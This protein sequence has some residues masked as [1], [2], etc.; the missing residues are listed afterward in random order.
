MC[1]QS[2][3]NKQQLM[4]QVCT[5][6]GRENFGWRANTTNYHFKGQN[7]F[8]WVKKVL[9]M[10]EQVC[11]PQWGIHVRSLSF[12]CLY[13]LSWISPNPH[14]FINMLTNCLN[15]I[16]LVSLHTIRQIQWYH[17]WVSGLLN[18]VQAD[19]NWWGA[20]RVLYMAS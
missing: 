15:K 10:E 18:T 11:T 8:Q 9:I 20:S 1:P 12:I 6:E 16:F 4:A 7:K 17:H 5:R 19:H 3:C 13:L 2:A 14:P